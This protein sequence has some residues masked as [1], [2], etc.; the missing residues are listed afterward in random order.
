M[1]KLSIISTLIV[2]SLLLTFSLSSALAADIE[3]IE[4]ENVDL[5]IVDS[6]AVTEE[7]PDVGL[8]DIDNATEE[9][10]YEFAVDSVALQWYLEGEA[11]TMTDFALEDVTEEY[12]ELA[13]N[14]GDIE[15]IDDLIMD[16][17]EIDA[18]ESPEEETVILDI[19]DEVIAEIT[20]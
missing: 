14:R 7:D 13:A 20:D 10:G 8:K 9:L 5:A 19:T 17:E 12:D 3:D 2:L 16:E 6:V 4:P 1:R 11:E 18:I 15:E